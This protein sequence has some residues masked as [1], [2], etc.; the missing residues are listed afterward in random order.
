VRNPGQRVELRPIFND[1]AGPCC[2]GAPSDSGVLK[3]MKRL[4][5]AVMLCAPLVVVAD[6]GDLFVKGDAARGEAK[7]ATCAACHGAQGVSANPEWPTLAGQGSVYTYLQLKAFKEGKRKNVLMSSQALGLSDEDMRD[8]AAFYASKA[9]KPGVASEAAVPVAEPLWRAG[10]PDR[11]IPACAGC[12]SPNGAGN[13]A[14]WYPQ[15][16]GQHATYTAASLRAYRA[17]ERGDG[18]QGQM[19]TAIAKQLSDEEIDALASF[20]NGLQ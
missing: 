7:A 18:V 1:L 19:M 4:L 17:G 11:Q 15:L 12:H 16:A 9:H 13:P 10:K 5:L 6:G 2:H 8:L 20:I 14:A 3:P